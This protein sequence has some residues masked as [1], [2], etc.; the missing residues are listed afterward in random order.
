MSLLRVLLVGLLVVGGLHGTTSVGAAEVDS[1]GPVARSTGETASRGATVQGGASMVAD[2]RVSRTV[3]YDRTPPRPGEVR[4]TVTFEVGTQVRALHQYFPENVTVTEV[5]GFERGRDPDGDRRLE[6]DGRTDR[7]S[8]VLRFENRTASLDRGRRV[9]KVIDT[10]TWSYLDRPSLETRYYDSVERGW[11]S[12]ETDASRFELDDRVA[13]E[14]TVTGSVVF[15]GAH[16]TYT[17]NATGERLEV[18]VPNAADPEIP[19]ERGLQTIVNASDRLEVGGR[20]GTVA[21]L[22]MPTGGVP[23]ERWDVSGLRM[24][25][26]SF[27]VLDNAS[28]FLWRHEYVHTRQEFDTT[29]Q[30]RWIREGSANYYAYLETVREGEFAYRSVPWWYGDYRQ[31]LAQNDTVLADPDTWHDLTDYTVGPI[32]LAALEA[33]IRN[34]ST[35]ARFEAVFRRMNRHEGEVSAA[36]FGRFVADAAGTSQR[37]WL[38]SHVNGSD[39]PAP[40][41]DPFRYTAGPES[42][43]DNDGLTVERERSLGTHPFRE[44]TDDDRLLDGNEVEVHGTD[45]TQEDTDDDGLADG[46][47]VRVHGTD[48]TVPNTGG[49]G[50]PDERDTGNETST[51]SGEEGDSQESSHPPVVIGSALV[52]FGSFWLAMVTAGVGVLVAVCRFLDGRI[53]GLPAFVVGRSLRRLGLL[54]A[55]FGALT[56]GGF[57]LVVLYG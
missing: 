7:P 37:G 39:V 43:A 46:D 53:V 8:V 57:L 41:R 48:P 47:E 13:G 1:S 28:A 24:G 35:D 9:P 56:V 21:M 12:S 14:G 38:A 29:R 31:S 15:M 42:D 2:S 17:R 10:P 19:P 36:D 50:T 51:E 54:V 5:K 26:N 27:W 40:P 3:S 18:V 49:D 6:W 16:E 34:E 33:R 22:V 45:P 32:A 25:E 11:Y 20:G 4:V 44:D 30:L 55:L 23:D 52:A